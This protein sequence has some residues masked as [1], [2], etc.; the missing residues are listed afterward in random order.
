MFNSCLERISDIEH[1][2]SC[3]PI[4]A[5]TIYR[6]NTTGTIIEIIHSSE[7]DGIVAL[8]AWCI[9]RLC[10]S[11]EVATGLVKQDLGT[12]LMRKGLSGNLMSSCFSAWCLG[13]LMFSDN[14]AEV[15]AEDDAAN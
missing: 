12:A 15:L 3:D 11:T 9:N 1:T 7:S 13:T 5:N 10:R 8:A 14:L 6:T 2:L 4:T